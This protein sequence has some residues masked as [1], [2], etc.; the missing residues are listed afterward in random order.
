MSGT[1]RAALALLVAVALTAVVAV[2]AAGDAPVAGGGARRP[3]DWVLDLAVS[4]LLVQMAVGAVLLVVLLVLRPHELIGPRGN[5]RTGGGRKALVGIVVVVLLVVVAVRRLA[6]GDGGVLSGLFGRNR[7]SSP[8]SPGGAS[9][10]EPEFATWPVIAVSGLLLLA[11]CAWL[12]SRRARRAADG[13]DRSLQAALEAALD[14]GVDD[15]LAEPDPRRAVIAAYARLEAVLAAYDVPRRPSE[16]P[17]EYLA[18]VLAVFEVSRAEISRLTALFQAAKF[19][20]RGVD[21][22]MKHDAIEALVATR[23][24]LRALREAEETHGREAQLRA[25]GQAP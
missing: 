12:L 23:G 3:S 19:S 6:S 9:G 13:D 4:L 7:T 25:A 2:A 18:R 17:L 21:E 8:L 5:A 24:E 15:L 1:R 10:Y 20:H 16:A 14:D 11:L 22:A